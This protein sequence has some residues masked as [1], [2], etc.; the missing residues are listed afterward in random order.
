MTE[1]TTYNMPLRKYLEL[2]PLSVRRSVFSLLKKNRHI[3]L[4]FKIT[5]T[6]EIMRVRYWFKKDDYF[7]GAPAADMRSARWRMSDWSIYYVNKYDALITLF[8]YEWE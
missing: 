8:K 7:V 6:G 4:R 3:V 1:D 2:L 5:T